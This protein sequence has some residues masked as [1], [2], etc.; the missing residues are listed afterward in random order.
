[1]VGMPRKRVG[2]LLLACVCI[3]AGCND[4]SPWD[5]EP[6]ESAPPL[7]GEFDPASCGT[8]A[9]RVVWDGP[10]PTFAP[11]IV[12]V[13]TAGGATEQRHYTNPNTPGID[14]AT[15]AIAGTVVFLDKVDLARSRPWDHDPVRVEI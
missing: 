15:R 2:S 8:I 4:S 3:M 10:L 9:G 13:P 7:A 14:V 6:V 11:I 12:S 1:M 5:A